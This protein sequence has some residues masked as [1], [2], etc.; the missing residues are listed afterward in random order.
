VTF[1]EDKLCG[2]FEL[3]FGCENRFSGERF[4]I[5]FKIFKTWKE[6]N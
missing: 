6:T 4:G 2:G 1:V 5:G 3:R